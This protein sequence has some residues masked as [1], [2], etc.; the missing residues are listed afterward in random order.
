MPF[1]NQVNQEPAYGVPGTF[2]SNNPSASVLAGEGALVAGLGGVTLG[3]FGWVQGD[4]TTVLNTPPGVT[5]G[6][7]ATAT[8]TLGTHTTYTVSALAV[9]AGGTGYAVGDT[10]TFTGGTATVATVSSGVVT[11][12]TIATATAQSTDPTA[13]GVVT[14]SSGAGTGLTLNV[15]ATAG[16]GSNGEVS[17][18]NVTAAGSGYTAVPTVTLSGGGGTGAAA[19]AVI[20]GGIV[21]GI[22]VTSGGTGYTSAPSVAITQTAAEPTAPDGFLLNDRSAWIADIYDE[23]TMVMPQGYMV[24]LKSQGDYFAVTKTAANRGQKVFASTTD[25]TL[26]ADVA[27]A[28]LAGSIETKFYVALGGLAGETI[29]ISTWDHI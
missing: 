8:A 21:T 28:T 27:G 24:D 7:G 5:P 29:T 10:V 1:Q 20:S 9:N 18:I 17:L 25:G 13:T 2:A 11:G 16:S 12:V 15:T 19:V 4:G 6:T 3:A 23:A 22:T 26:S 14:T